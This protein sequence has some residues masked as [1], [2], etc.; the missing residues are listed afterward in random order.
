MTVSAIA[1]S[2][3]PPVDEPSINDHEVVTVKFER[4]L[5]TYAP[6]S[7]ESLG[8]VIEPIEAKPVSWDGPRD[9]Q[10]PQNWSASKKWL[11]MA[12]NGITTINMYV[13][14]VVLQG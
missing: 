2:K 6:D 12:V 4:Y 7:L 9:P 10:N 8:P 13:L 5:G 3:T 14:W 1:M 11:I